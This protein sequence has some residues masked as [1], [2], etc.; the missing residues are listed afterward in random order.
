MVEADVCCGFGGTFCVKYPDISNVMVGDK[1][2]HVA[3]TGA[4][5]LLAGDLGCLMNMAGKAS[6]EG[7]AFKARHVV[8]V[9]AGDLGDARDRRAD[10]TLHTPTTPAFKAN[11]RTRDGEREPA[12]CAA[13]R[14]R[15]LH[16]QARR[17]RARRC[18]SSTTCATGRG[19]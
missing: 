1:T 15:Q 10:M 13:Q 6:R 11:A 7:R 14:P 19:T 4:D 17:R 8:E 3:A 5:L 9:L 12:D 16:P 2:R 18:P